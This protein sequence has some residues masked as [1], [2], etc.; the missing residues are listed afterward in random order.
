MRQASLLGLWRDPLLRLSLP[1]AKAAKNEASDSLL[2]PASSESSVPLLAPPEESVSL[3]N[4]AAK[5]A[6]LSLPIPPPKEETDSLPK[7]PKE[8]ESVSLPSDVSVI[9]LAP[10]EAPRLSLPKPPED[11]VSPLAPVKKDENVSLLTA[12]ILASP[13]SRPE[14]SVSLPIAPAAST[15]EESV[16][17]PIA[18]AADIP[19]ES[20]SLPPAAPTAS[21]RSRKKWLWPPVELALALS[22]ENFSP[23]I[24]SSVRRCSVERCESAP[25][26]DALPGRSPRWRR[27]RAAVRSSLL[28]IA[29]SINSISR[30]KLRWKGSVANFG[31][32]SPASPSAGSVTRPEEASAC[33]AP[34]R[35]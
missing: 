34:L 4:P 31:S 13:P 21:C 17:L 24:I 23:R 27:A 8:E 6:R 26:S 3:L 20:V 18:P 33:H 1:P 14:E 25:S 29:P 12:V 15:P 19:E 11:S 5:A 10:A 22:M 7:P 30:W 32:V 2:I 28:P 16:S 35:P 9:S